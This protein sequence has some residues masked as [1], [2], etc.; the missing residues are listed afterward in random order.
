MEVRIRES[1]EEKRSGEGGAIILWSNLMITSRGFS[2]CVG[3]SRGSCETIIA[4]PG[5]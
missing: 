2:I 4:I 5:G 3:P 1:L